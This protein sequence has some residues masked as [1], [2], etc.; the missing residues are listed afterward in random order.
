MRQWQRLLFVA[1][2]AGSI[3]GAALFAMQVV[4]IHPLIERA[5]TYERQNL[6]PS[7]HEHADAWE[8]AEGVERTTY[9]AL[10]TVLTG[11]A[12]AAIVLG[13]AAALGMNLDRRQG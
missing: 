8:P 2:A 3:A 13:L 7:E 9:T 11:V 1:L 12:F 5:E 10:G 6:A 4:A